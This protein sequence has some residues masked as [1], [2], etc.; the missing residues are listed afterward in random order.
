MF[1][2]PGC[3]NNFSFFS[4]PKG[5]RSPTFRQGLGTACGVVSSGQVHMQRRAEVAEA[6]DGLVTG[7][8]RALEL[9]CPSGPAREAATLEQGG[10]SPQDSLRPDHLWEELQHVHGRAGGHWQRGSLSIP[11][12]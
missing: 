12:T 4:G 2:N 11:S 9:G 8:E 6:V 1:E 3:P 10:D 7:S 5:P